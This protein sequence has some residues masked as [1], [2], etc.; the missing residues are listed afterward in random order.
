MWFRKKTLSKSEF[1]PLRSVDSQMR[2]TAH[3]RHTELSGEKLLYTWQII[4]LIDCNNCSH[5]N[6]FDFNFISEIFTS[7]DH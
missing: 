4:K 6:L 3:R 1:D 2:K 7:N 5:L